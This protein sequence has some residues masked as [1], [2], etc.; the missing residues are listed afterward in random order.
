MKAI[1]THTQTGIV[2]CSYTVVKYVPER[3]TVASRALIVLGQDNVRVFVWS[4]CIR[5][6]ILRAF[7]R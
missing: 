2:Y 4:S 1:A 3:R 5:L 7:L 6:F